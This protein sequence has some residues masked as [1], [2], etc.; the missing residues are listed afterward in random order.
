MSIR[1]SLLSRREELRRR[2]EALPKEI[3]A[4][5]ARSAN[6]LDFQA[7]YSQLGAIRVLMEEYLNRQQT[8]LSTLD[9]GGHAETFRRGALAL[10]EDII[11]ARKGLGFLQEEVRIALLGYLQ[12]HSLGR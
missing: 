8:L 3:E 7:H 4:W 9:P 2:V 12:R 6:E 1:A 10:I 11:K 5:R